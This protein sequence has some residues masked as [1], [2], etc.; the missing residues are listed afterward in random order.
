M[1]FLVKFGINKRSLTV[2]KDYQT[3]SSVSLISQSELHLKSF[4]Y[5]PKYAVHIAINTSK[6]VP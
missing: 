6:K 5:L 3:F 2:Q 1:I 4:D